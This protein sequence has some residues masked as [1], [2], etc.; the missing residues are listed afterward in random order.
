MVD[1][2]SPN[3]SARFFTARPI[4]PMPRIPRALPWGSCPKSR[5]FLK[6]PFLKDKREGFS[7]R[8]APTMRKMVKSAVA[9]VTGSGAYVTVISRLAQA[10][11][12]IWS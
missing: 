1:C 6:F 2:S 12:S 5:P 8:R 10:V 3:G 7:W 4:L 9:S 11:T